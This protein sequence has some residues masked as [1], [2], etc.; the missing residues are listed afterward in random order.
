M[1]F[2]F[3]SSHFHPFERTSLSKPRVEDMIAPS[4]TQYYNMSSENQTLKSNI[5]HH[6]H[7]LKSSTHLK[8]GDGMKTCIKFVAQDVKL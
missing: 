3:S 6:S 8:C 5:F 7:R 2:W 4:H 1:V